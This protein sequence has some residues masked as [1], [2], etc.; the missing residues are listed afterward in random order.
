VCFSTISFLMA[1]A[2]GQ[3]QPDFSGVINMGTSSE[4]K[5]PRALK[6]AIISASTKLITPE[7]YWGG[8]PVRA[9]EGDMQ[10]VVGPW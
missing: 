6:P 10:V 8:I 7:H 9:V 1:P 5:Q 2:S 3:L 4:I